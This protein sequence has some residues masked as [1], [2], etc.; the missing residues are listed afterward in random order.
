[1]TFGRE[2]PD[3]VA[4]AE[5]KYLARLTGIYADALRE[6]ALAAS[7]RFALVAVADWQPPADGAVLTLAALSRLRQRK[8]AALE[9][10]WDKIVADI[11]TG[12][13]GAEWDASA[14]AV[15]ALVRNSVDR[16]GARIAT[17]SQFILRDAVTEAYNEN[18][19]KRAATA[20]IRARMLDAA[21]WQAD[22][23]AQTDVTSLANGASTVAAGRAGMAY[24]TWV[25]TLDDRTRPSHEVAH[26]Q[27]VPLNGMFTVGAEEALYPGDPNLSDDEAIN[28]RCTVAY[29]ETLDDAEALLADGGAIIMSGMKARQRAKKRARRA[30]ARPPA[31]VAGASGGT[32]PLSD[33]ARA[34]DGGA[35][36][37]RWENACGIGGDNPDWSKFHTGFFWYDSQNAQTVG[38]HHLLF[39]DVI[40]GT[41]T[42]VWRGVTTCAA[43]MQGSRGA[44]MGYIPAADK[45]RIRTRIGGYYAA[46]RRKYKDDSIQTP[47]ASG[48]SSA[49]TETDRAADEKG[50]NL[51]RNGK[52]QAVV[53]AA[54]PVAFSGIATIEGQVSDDNAVAPRVILPDA[55]SWPEMPVS[56]MAQT[57]TAEHHDGAE[58]AGR[59]DEFARRKRR[60]GRMRDIYTAGELTTPFGVDEIAPMIGDKTMRYVSVDLGASVWSLVDRN[61]FELVS[62]EDFDLEKAMN[63]GYALGCTDGKI[64]ALTLVA[65]QAI[66]G[67]MVALTASADSYGIGIDDLG[68]EALL[69]AAVTGEY[70]PDHDVRVLIA[71]PELQT[72]NGALVAAARTWAPARAWFEV[73]EPPGKMPLTVQQDGQ[74]YGHLATWDSCHASFLPSCV[75]PPRSPSNYGR[76]HT[77]YIDTEDGGEVNVGKLMFSGDGGHADRGLNPVKASQYYDRTGMVA[78]VLR[79]VDGRFGIWVCGS[80]NPDLSEEQR[81][82]MRRQLRMFPPSGDWRPYPDG[83]DL[84]CGLAVS[85]PGFGIPNDGVVL[86]TIVASG[87]ANGDDVVDTRDAI[88]A[89]SGWFPPDRAALDALGIVDEEAEAEREMFVLAARAAG[90]LDAMAARVIE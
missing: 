30:A 83:Y 23:L 17:A 28:C 84:L 10:I 41:T 75:P 29:G 24:K 50:D 85:I 69:A 65:T 79:A 3:I 51:M 36:L 81:E 55:L 77:S 56:F 73:P 42:A 7:D 44:V 18:L 38:A 54:R 27:T 60:T 31:I 64:K 32:Y 5:E 20:L 57:V 2:L 21:P 61:T 19:D 59:V 62:Q 66:E 70:R 40:N 86:A 47:W 13:P 53:A 68:P 43:A 49:S 63:G 6:L 88:I 8:L 74:V 67:A 16:V 78:A 48:S 1:M 9:P 45:A 82:E 71:A 33:R 58:V 37:Q 72:T 4:S 35:A 34:W 87:D 89:S 15:R 12:L 25:A 76:F 14:P 26:G 52:R 80:L 39:V 46:A 11:G 22:A 90:G